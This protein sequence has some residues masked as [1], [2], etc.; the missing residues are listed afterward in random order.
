VKVAFVTP[1]YGAEVIGGAESG[2]RLLAEHLAASGRAEVEV[3]STCALD[4]RTWANHY[5]PGTT[6]EGG[7][8]VHRFASKSVRHPDFDAR[9]QPVLAHPEAMS[10][11]VC[12][13]W[14]LEQGPVCPDAVDAAAV[15]ANDVVAFYPYLYHP[16]VTGVPRLG[17][18]A[19]MHPAAHDEAPL[20]L[21]IFHEVFGAAAGFV[22]QTEAER[23]LVEERFPAVAGAHQVLV[24]LGV[25]E[26]P[27]TAE[28]ARSR[29]AGR[30]ADGDPYL[31]C[32]GRVDRGKGT[33]ALA[34]FFDAYKAR[35]PGP[36]ALV[37]A[38][39]V[40]HPIPSHPDIVMA[41]S[42]DEAT[43]W[44]LLR[45][46]EA[47]VSPSG[48]ESFSIVVNEAWAA[49]VPVMVN[50]LC[51]PTREHCEISGGGLWYESYAGFEV[52]LDRLRQSPELASSMAQRGRAYVDARFRWSV[53]V[54]RYLAFCE[55]VARRG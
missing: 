11:E 7:V 45:G 26:S 42:V 24:G 16:T 10:L 1:R 23:H 36:L 37:F 21:P 17:R 27:G 12:R 29:L 18:R 53:I 22:F 34:R 2:A 31:L 15:S 47:L 5:R 46:A 39:P 35:R 25:D 6:S 4:A 48:Y 20:R 19:V 28:A 33:A 43:K 54:D 9:S 51:G 8:T 14:I 13:R 32:L 40:V 44:G 38:G 55:R 50:G 41:G 49:G 52:A 3:F 30:L